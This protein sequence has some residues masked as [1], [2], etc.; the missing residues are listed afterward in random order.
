[1]RGYKVILCAIA[2]LL[3][4]MPATTRA[5]GGGEI[6]LPA[7]LSATDVER[8]RRIETLQE[9]GNWRAADAEIGRLQNPLLMGHVLFQR[10]MHPTAYRSSYDELHDWLARYADHPDADRIHAL[11]LRRKP[12]GAQAP[13]EPV[14]TVSWFVPPPAAVSVPTRD[15]SS[16]Q[17]ARARTIERSID[18]YIRQGWPSKSLEILEQ[19][20][21]QSLLSTAQSARARADIAASY[22]AERVDDKALAQAETALRESPEHVGI[23]H[24]VAGLASWRLGRHAAAAR[25]FEQMTAAPGI[26]GWNVAAGAFWAARAHLVD[27]RPDQVNRWLEVAARHPRSFYGILARRALGFATVFDWSLPGLSTAHVEAFRSSAPARR[28][29]ALLQVGNR[30]LAEQELLRVDGRDNTLIAEALLAVADAADLPNLSMKVGQYLRHRTGRDY[31]AALYP[32]PHWVPDGGYTVDRALVFAFMRQES[33]FKADA[34]SHAGARGLM[35]LMPGTASFVAG[36]GSFRKRS[37]Q[38]RLYEPELNIALG[39]QYLEHLIGLDSVHGDLFRLAVAYNGGPGNLA[40]W[41]R[42]V[43]YNGDPLLFIET[44]PSRETRIFIE[45][46]MTNFWIYRQRLGQPSPSLDTLATGEWPRYAQLGNGN[47][48][49]HVASD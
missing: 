17:R 44:L 11:A 2:V 39:Q 36:D 33:R 13:R 8:Y 25:H 48:V 3:A 35:Q 15:L 14:G 32:L 37:G 38:K 9:A 41:E 1:M 28:G 26:S 29:L 42:E 4:G 34:T 23:A 6:V 16:K 21:S 5:A 18:Q 46:V 12:R 49:S 45:R 7:E 47:K 31:D 10:Y 22:L 20:E 19:R 24:W 43:P 27:R 40:R 30:D